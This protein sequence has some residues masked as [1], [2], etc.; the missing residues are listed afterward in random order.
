M[1]GRAS[2]FTM[3]RTKNIGKVLG[4]EK[5]WLNKKE[6]AA[7]LGV[8]ERYVETNI[9]ANPQIDIYRISERVFLYSK[10]SID[11]MVLKSKI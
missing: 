3:G 1:K 2:F 8:S 11:K 6:T 10:S 4:V 7:Y 9:N 5:I